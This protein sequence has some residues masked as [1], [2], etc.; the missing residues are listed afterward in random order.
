M[1][2]KP[3]KR[4]PPKRPPSRSDIDQVVVITTHMLLAILAD[5]RVKFSPTS[6]VWSVFAST[7]PPNPLLNVVPLG[8]L[9]ERIDLLVPLTCNSMLPV[10]SLD[11]ERSVVQGRL[12][13]ELGDEIAELRPRDDHLHSLR[14]AFGTRST[15]AGPDVT[16]VSPT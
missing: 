9:F 5:G 16:G 4:R 6:V 14:A 8:V 13:R 7:D 2:D 11:S 3:I 1:S 12:V 15:I 10:E